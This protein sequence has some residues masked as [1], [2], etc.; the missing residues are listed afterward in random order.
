MKYNNEEDVPF[1][2]ST[3]ARYVT[4]LLSEKVTFLLLVNLSTFSFLIW[5][6]KGV[7]YKRYIPEHINCKIMKLL[8]KGNIRRISSYTWLFAKNTG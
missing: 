1:N 7:T 8:F 5:L 6:K 2:C 4:R 3:E